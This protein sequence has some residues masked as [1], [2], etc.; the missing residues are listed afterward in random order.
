MTEDGARVMTYY[1]KRY[2]SNQQTDL[3]SSLDKASTPKA[4]N[5]PAFM[6]DSVNSISSMA[7][8]GRYKKVRTSGVTNVSI[9]SNSMQTSLGFLWIGECI[10]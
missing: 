5:V 10:H 7:S 2:N 6:A 3:K 1:C 4:P 9:Y 8:K